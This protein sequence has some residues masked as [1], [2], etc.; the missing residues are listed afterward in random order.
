MRCSFTPLSLNSL[1]PPRGNL[2]HAGFVQRGDLLHAFQPGVMRQLQDVRHIAL[3]HLHHRAEFLVE[4]RAQRIA[5]QFIEPDVEAD[6]R[7]KRHLA[8]RDEHAAV[9]TVV[10]GQQLALRR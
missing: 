6:V 10:I 4:Q 9:G 8:Q 1:S 7:G 3:A 5:V 2:D